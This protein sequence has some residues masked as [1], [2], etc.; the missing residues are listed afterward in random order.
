ME[1]S[2][3]ARNSPRDISVVVLDTAVQA[4]T[5]CLQIS[6]FAR[7]NFRGQGAGEG[8]GGGDSF[9][10]YVACVLTFL[11]NAGIGFVLDFQNFGVLDS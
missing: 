1:R 2:L 5:L 3:A 4:F 6:V 9:D 10:P 7:Y 11:S 8:V